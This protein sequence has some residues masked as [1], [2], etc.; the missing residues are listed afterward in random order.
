MSE[1]KS[2]ANENATENAAKPPATVQ[3]DIR[4]SL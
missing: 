2:N 3:P 4:G 1:I